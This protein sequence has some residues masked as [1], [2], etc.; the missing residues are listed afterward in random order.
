MADRE[1]QAEE[2]RLGLEGIRRERHATL[3]IVAGL[4]DVLAR[5]VPASGGWSVAQVISHLIK[6]DGVYRAEIGKLIELKAAG[7]RPVVEVSLREL[8]TRPFFVPEGLLPYLDLPFRL[9]N[10]VLPSQLR[11]YLTGNAVIP[12]NAPDEASPRPDS[13]LDE[14]RDQAAASTSQI[15]TMLSGRDV[16]GMILDHPMMGRHTVPS[17]L[18]ILARHEERHQAQISRILASDTLPAAAEAPGRG[19]RTASAGR[20]AGTASAGSGE[21]P[22]SAGSGA[23]TA[24]PGSGSRRLEE[25]A[26][27]AERAL[28]SG[29]QIVSWWKD[30]TLLDELKLFPLKPAYEPYYQMQGFFDSI[31]LLGDMKPTPIMGCLQRHRFKRRRPPV[32]EATSHLESFIDQHFLAKCLKTRPDGKSGGFRYRP[33]FVRD[34]DG[35]LV[36]PEDKEAHGADLSGFRHGP[37]GVLQVDILDFVRANPMLAK[38]DDVLSRFI[39]ESAY[40]VIHEDL[41]VAP[42]DTPKGVIAER[43]FGYAFLPRSVEHNLFG[44]GP[45]KFSAAIK[46]WRFLLFLNGDVEVQVAFVVTRSQKV[47]DINGFDPIY[48]SLHLA[49]AF[50]LGML[51]L[52]ERGHDAMDKV[53]LEHHGAV[54]AD[55]VM[56]FQDIWEGQRWAPSFGSW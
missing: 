45:G 19:A 49:D 46:Q 1:S 41:A 56:D 44:F 16:S 6:T 9:V 22:A 31:Q 51:G 28:K 15:E 54:H 23:R 3:D 18:R 39:R 37:H 50:S 14:L 38:Y 8:N 7:R 24:S 34:K 20:G 11:E 12:F 21:A 26:Q 35:R 43:V 17:L 4:D 29:R 48:A 36:E 42:T 5:R 55:V 52:R 33:I 40:V 27:D 32:A 10:R 13:P 53:F 47:L 30:K 2:L 25:F